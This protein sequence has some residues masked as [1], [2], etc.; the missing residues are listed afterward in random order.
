M[1]LE[2]FLSFGG[3]V[4]YGMLQTPS[5]LMTVATLGHHDLRSQITSCPQMGQRYE[6]LDVVHT[7]LISLP[8]PKQRFF[9][10]GPT[11]SLKF[12]GIWGMEK[13]EN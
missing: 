7:H 10:T 5:V 3:R 11:K 4:N 2:V 1:I 8:Q 9:P 12:Q 6:V 13:G